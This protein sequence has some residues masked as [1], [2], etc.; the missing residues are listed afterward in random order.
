MRLGNNLRKRWMR[1]YNNHPYKGAGHVHHNASV[2]NNQEH[3]MD[4][5]QFTPL[6]LWPGSSV[7]MEKVYF[8]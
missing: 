1:G 6:S 8:L 4:L 2:E 7:L 3:L 5:S